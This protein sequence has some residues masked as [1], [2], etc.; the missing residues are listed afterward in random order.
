MARKQNMNRGAA[1]T[2][3]IAEHER[4]ALSERDREAFF[5]A[6]T[7]PPEPSE[8]LRRALAEHKVRIAR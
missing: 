1:R 2:R 6:L 5:D 8:R 3:T 4:L 7:H